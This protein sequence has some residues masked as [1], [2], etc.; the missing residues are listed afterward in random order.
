MSQS[1]LRVFSAQDTARALDYPAMIQSM[2]TLFAAGINAPLRHHHL[3]P[4]TNESNAML[5][6]MPAW[7]Q[8]TS[9]GGVKIVTVFPDNHLR[10]LPA[11]SGS[12]LLFDETTGQHLALIEGTTLTARRTAA[13]SVLAAKYLADPQAQTL[14]VVG[15]GRVAQA[16]PEAFASQFPLKK[17]LIW[18]RTHSHA[19]HLAEHWRTQGWSVEVVL[20]LAYG[21]A[22]ADIISCATLS[23]HPLIQGQWLQAG[24]HLDLIGSFTPQMR[25]TDD[26]CMK[27]AQI[28]IDTEAALK[29]AGD[30]VIPLANGVITADSI[31]GTFY[32]LCAEKRSH[33]DPN[34]MTLFKGVGHAV[35]D[36]ACAMVAYQSTTKTN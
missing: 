1:T 33:Y 12:Y 17:L 22:K 13:A 20:D 28:Y 9:L 29:E 10:G 23:P 16:L 2:E 7:Q 34:R 35:E 32:Q 31:K 8:G 19:E 30:L 25:E 21:V 5:L 18:S 6:L 27:R 14:L 36:L 11:I 3:M 15:S 26:D 4:R 24:Q